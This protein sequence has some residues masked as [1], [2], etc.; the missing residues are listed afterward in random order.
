[1]HIMAF[2]PEEITI[3]MPQFV[4]MDTSS[5]AF[6]IGGESEISVP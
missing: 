5:G 2:F 4:K 3:L 1:M 6:G